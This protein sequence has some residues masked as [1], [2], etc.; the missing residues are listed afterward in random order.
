MIFQ[1]E[2]RLA[3]K[4]NLLSIIIVLTTALTISALEIRQKKIYGL[5]AL[6]EHGTEKAIL[7]AQFS[8]YAVFSE[9]QESLAHAIQGKNDDET[10]YLALLR[11]DKTLLIESEYRTDF[12][13]ETLSD[14]D[15]SSQYDKS[16][17]RK[18]VSTFDD[19]ENIQFIC[20][21]VSQ[22]SAFDPLEELDRLGNMLPEVI[23]YVQLVFTKQHMRQQ[24][25][26]STRTVLLLTVGIIALAIIATL[27]VTKKITIPINMLI[28]ETQ[29]ISDGDLTGNIKVGGGRELSILAHNY[30]RMIE[31]LRNSH[32]DVE[33]YQAILENKIEERTLEL[34][35][36]RRMVVALRAS[37]DRLQTSEAK[38][39]G[40]VESSYDWIWEV[41]RDGIYTYASPQVEKILGYKAEDI[42]GKSPFDFML[43][44]EKEKIS[45]LFKESVKKMAPIVAL[46]NTG[47]HKNG[48]SVVVET[49]ASP[50]FDDTGQVAGY[51]GIDRDISE[52]LRTEEQIR[53]LNSLREKLLG[54]AN[55]KQK[56]TCVT[57]EI[58]DIFDADFCGIWLIKPGDLCHNGCPHAQTTEGPHVCTHRSG[59]LHLTTSSGRHSGL[60]SGMHDRVP[61]GCYKIGRI[62]SGDIPSFN[63]NDVTQDPGIHD[64]EWA[65]QLGLVSSTGYKLF[66]E[67]VEPLGVLEIFSK[68]IIGLN[69]V[70]LLEGVATN[71][72]QVIQVTV[73]EEEKEKI[74]TQLL[75]AQKMEAIGMMAGG[76]AHDLN[77]ILAGIV[78]YPE[79]LLKQLPQ[80]SDLKKPLKAIQESGERAATVVADLL[81][82]A[83][84][85]ASIRETHDINILVQEYLQSPEYKQLISSHP[86]VICSQ[87]YDSQDP[88]I[89]CSPVHIKKTIMNL[90]TNAL[91]AVENNGEITISTDKTRVNITDSKKIGLEPGAYARLTVRDNGSGIPV[92]D[93]EHI[94]EPFYTR[95]FMGHS[96]TG[97][98]LA[99]VWNTMQD[100]N[101]KVFVDSNENGTTFQ[102]YFPVSKEKIDPV[103]HDTADTNSCDSEHIL[104]VD[105]EPL[106]RDIAQQMLQAMGYVVDTISSGELALEFIKET[107][108]DL[109]MLD[110]KMDPGMTGRQTYEKMLT[111]NPEQK[112]IV[113]SGFS[114]SE[115]IKE[116]LRLGAGGFVKKPYSMDSLG[117]VI[118][119]TL[120]S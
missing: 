71:I 2:L 85:A 99:I 3:S 47:V 29:K 84:G 117:R 109:I 62:A 12:K 97:L 6:L 114:E 102:L 66:A 59:C 67:D 19:G 108:V 8:E 93:L 98:G 119:E 83:R 94:F 60:D 18:A 38:F 80:S 92:H 11:A 49:S 16:S 21:V 61:F 44:K 33:Q 45:V 115:D 35:E 111:I 81:T 36:R 46:V 23:G 69:E 5:E 63:T 73:A 91:E 55:L 26:K 43:P 89:S 32:D 95:K 82:V 100:H 37:E 17:P 41:D 118:K 1:K 79:L 28:K 76:V 42:I 57:E 25:N 78:G 9:D 112:A 31:R 72:S 101:G 10:V 87:Q 88:L 113:A 74:Q 86:G 51:C 27:V 90:I 107:P 75:R 104:V 103:E 34:A 20:P 58:L 40:L 53:A 14:I 96:G 7:I 70:G 116:T 68:H 77:N 39:R 30:N 106:L 4:F 120:K 65:K 64:Q 48:Q 24:I 13:R 22:P 52:R 50:F 54:I 15:G 105:D 110:M 56:L